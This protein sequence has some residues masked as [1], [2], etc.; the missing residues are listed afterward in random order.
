MKDL[1]EKHEKEFDKIINKNGRCCNDSYEYLVEIDRDCVENFISKVRKESIEYERQRI[2]K[3][4]KEM[5]CE[6]PK[7]KRVKNPLSLEEI[8]RVIYYAGRFNYNKAI[9]DILKEL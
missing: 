4:I 1:I 9:G 5:V 3:M 8:N 6:V 2:K 7:D